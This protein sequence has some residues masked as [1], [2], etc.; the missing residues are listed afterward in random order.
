MLTTVNTTLY[1]TLADGSL[2][3]FWKG[4]NM[5]NKTKKGMMGFDS[6]AVALGVLA[7]VV[8]MILVVLTQVLN[9]ATVGGNADANATIT[10]AIDAVAL[11]GDFFAIIVIL[12]I[13]VGIIGLLYMVTRGTGGGQA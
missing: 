12:G 9:V 2:T 8:A 7:I 11:Y 13:F 3:S 10:S 6:M 4:E 1:I 5:Q